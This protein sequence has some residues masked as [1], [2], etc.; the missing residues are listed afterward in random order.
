LPAQN[1]LACGRQ[2]EKDN[3]QH[4]PEESC[5]DEPLVKSEEH[6]KTIINEIGKVK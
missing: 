2:A 4:H 6:S 3:A 5:H 1:R